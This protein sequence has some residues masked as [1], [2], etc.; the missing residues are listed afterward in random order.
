MNKI[1]I[2]ALAAALALLLVTQ[3]LPEK[4]EIVPCPCAGTITKIHDIQGSGAK[5]PLIGKTV[6]V[7]AVVVGDFSE[8]GGLGGFFL[9]EED[10]DADS[11]PNTSE[12]IFIYGGDP[13]ANLTVGDLVCVTGTISEYK[14][15][16][17]IKNVTKTTICGSADLPSAISVTLPV[18][19]QDAWESVE[20]MR[21]VLPQKLTVTDTYGLGRYGEVVL[22]NGRLF[23]PTEVADPGEPAQAV[24][25]KNA[26]NRIVLDDGNAAQNPDP[27][28]YPIGGLAANRPLRDGDTAIG[29]QGVV[30]YSY[31]E[32]L[33]EPTVMPTFT[34]TNPR[35]PTAPDVGGNLRVA[36][37][38]VENYFN[39]DG[40]GSGFPTARGAATLPDFERQ[41]DKLVKAL[42]GLNADIIG[43]ME[44]END[45]FGP[46]SAIYDIVRGMNA[47]APIGTSYAYVAPKVDQ[48]GTDAITV[49]LVYRAPTVKPAGNPAA[50]A[51]TDLPEMNRPPLAQTFIDKTNGAELTVVVSHF[52]SKS[53]SSAHGPDRDQKDGQGC[54]NRNRTQAASALLDWLATDPTKTDD[55]DVLIIGDLN[56]YTHEDPIT[57]LTGGG[58]TDL[59][60][61][62][63]KGP[64]YTYVYKGEAGALDHALG[65]ATLVSQVRGAAV[66][67]IDADEAPALGYT[68]LYKSKG[69]VESLYRN[70]PY[71]AS[72]HDPIVIGIDL[73]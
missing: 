12:G 44:I 2:V 18:S 73:K 58:Y 9:Q 34:T 32:Y 8:T 14:G 56:C 39:G 26:L 37:F 63:S 35:K 20:G 57:T 55:P 6:T 13:S 46:Q 59:L 19:S 49:A 17:E 4:H 21:V 48:L 65:S 47:A 51:M 45:G 3:L 27:I 41:R 42:V 23:N 30:T 1:L 36:S 64:Q 43:L 28:L 5:S 38:N 22:S 52:K 60:S 72:D 50:M 25:A 70:D 66:W 11:D 24:M 71:R 53:P 61:R 67:H 15:L 62:F 69:Q 68:S 31:G 7:E 29:V 54:W 16:T 10:R 40:C 33:I